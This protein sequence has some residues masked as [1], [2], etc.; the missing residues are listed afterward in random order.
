MS[1]SGFLLTDE[2]RFLLIRVSE[3]LDVVIETLGI[4]ENEEAMMSIREALRDSREGRVRGYEEFI[5]EMKETG[6]I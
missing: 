2:D 3:L 1:E 6:E 5:A 4:I